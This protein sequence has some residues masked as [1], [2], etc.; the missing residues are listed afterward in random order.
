MKHITLMKAQ[1]LL[2][3][4]PVTQGLSQAF[5]SGS[6]GA[7]GALIVTN[8][9]TLN[10]PPT[11]VF[12]FTTISVSAAGTLSFNTNALNTPVY[13]LATGDV[14]IAGTVDVSGLP[15]S[16]T[17][18]G[19]GGPGGFEGGYG[20]Y[21]FGATTQ[22]G[23]GKGPGGG[24]YAYANFR[25]SGAF[26]SAGYQNPAVYGNVLLYPLIG[27]S[28]GTGNSGGPGAGGGGGGGAILIASNT[29]IQV[30]GSIRAVGGSG[31]QACG[32]SGG[33]IRLVSPLVTGTGSLRTTGGSGYAIGGNGRIRIDSPDAYAFR[34]LQIFE[35][36]MT[37]GSQMFVFRPVTSRLDIVELAGQA[38]P[39]G[40]QNPVQIVLAPGVATNATITIQAHDFSADIPIAVVVTPENVLSTTY[41]T[42]I[43]FTGNP[44]QLQLSIAIPAGEVSHVDVWTR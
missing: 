9:V 36:V 1:A 33:G 23:D 37:H 31:V 18:P 35:A 41:N 44:S 25:A 29:R 43:T 34:S 19:S 2:C 24:K 32:G 14:N 42:N 38:I 26:G 8:A 27:G 13:L 7:D 28:G 11:G 17:L 3:L 5:T 4:L 40:T 12:N 10:L 21:G 22:G 15:S 39:L 30:D 20:G 6:T 16:G